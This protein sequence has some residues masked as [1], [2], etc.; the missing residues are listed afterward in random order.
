[1]MNRA[2]FFSIL[3][4]APIAAMM[5]KDL[6]AEPQIGDTKHLVYYDHGWV[7]FPTVTHTT[8]V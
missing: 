7:T 6:K 8:S 5:I 1:M 3:V 2:K 4:G